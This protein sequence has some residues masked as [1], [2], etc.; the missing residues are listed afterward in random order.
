MVS[1]ISVAAFSLIE[2]AKLTQAL[3]LEEGR[4]P[5]DRPKARVG[6]TLVVAV[7]ERIGLARWPP[8]FRVPCGR[9]PGCSSVPAQFVEEVVDVVQL[10]GAGD[11]VVD[12]FA[13]REVQHAEAEG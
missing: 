1:G 3:A 5:E 4:L 11:L 2:P 12:V 13:D 7:G 6:L 10:A 9:A 8:Q